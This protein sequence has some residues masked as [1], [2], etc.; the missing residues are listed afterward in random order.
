ML[1]SFDS[2]WIWRASSSA[3]IAPVLLVAVAQASSLQTQQLDVQ[4]GPWAA[5]LW[6]HVPCTAGS[7]SIPDGPVSSDPGI[8][9]CEVLTA[10]DADVVSGAV[11]F[12]AGES[13]RLGE[14]FSVAA[15]ASLEAIVGEVVLG[16][17]Y[18]QDDSPA[19]VKEYY[20]SFHLNP[21]RLALGS[22]TDEA[23]HF[24]AFDG[25]GRREFSISLTFHEASDEIRLFTT[26]WDD[27]GSP[28]TTE[29][30]C[31]LA[32]GSGW[33]TVEVHWKAST[34]NDGDVELS[35]DGAPAQSLG[36]CLKLS[37][38]VANEKG[39]IESIRWGANVVNGKNLGS[40]DL[41]GFYSSQ[42]KV[43]GPN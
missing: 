25:V 40:L 20:V 19:H 6:I 43:L 36:Q 14:G 10:N 42:P 12:R 22:D 32:L 39:E 16:A 33:Q 13:I 15:G 29:G 31:E 8:E 18:V 23:E 9:P 38:G 37:K 30:K 24:V 11:H 7:A 17:A 21:D 2:R 41:D 34:G 28:Y 5:R 35:L 26:I 1:R 3:L 4:D 27:G